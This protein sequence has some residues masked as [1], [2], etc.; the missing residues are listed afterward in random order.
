MQKLFILL[1]CTFILLSGT[2]CNVYHHIDY[3][4]VSQGLIKPNP[5][6]EKLVQQARRGKTE[7]YDALALCY[8]NG[9]GVKQ[10]DFNMMTMYLLSCK[11]SGKDI[12]KII[13]SLGEDDPI[14]LLMDAL[15][16][17]RI[18]NVPQES[19][20]KLR[21]ISP[22]DAL[23]YDA[24][25]TFREKND[26]LMAEQLIQKAIAGGSD[27]ACIIQIATYELLGNKEKLKQALHKYADRFP[28]LYVRLGEMYM[29][30]EI[31]EH[32]EQ[33]VKYFTYAD[34]YGMLTMNGAR[35]L[36]NAYRML[37]EKGKIKYDRQEMRRLKKLAQ[38]LPYSP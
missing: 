25:Y 10:S 5:K 23:I 34:K 18:E 20:E 27:M 4:P 7:A 24:F 1:Y 35:S 15:C 13:A 30:G 21:N 37:E 36:S 19:I 14:H 22:A 26:T 17:S 38:F 33:A 16:H 31:E 29:R 12:K 8:R 32:L 2:S 28:V 3:P 11:K 6:I 9:E